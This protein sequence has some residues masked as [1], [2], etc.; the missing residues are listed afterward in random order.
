MK[1]AQISDLHITG[2]GPTCGVA[3]MAENLARVVAHINAHGADMVLVTG[4]ICHNGLPAEATRAATVLAG[5]S[6]PY[7]ITP[8]NHD[9]RA[10][11]Q[12]AFPPA[13]LPAREKAH[14]SYV[15]ETGGLRFIALDSTDPDAPNGR[16]CP[17]RAAW[18]AARLAESDQ[19]VILFLHHPPMKCG[20]E[21][22]DTPPLEGASRL[23]AVVAEY[24]QILRILCGHIHLPAQA[25]WQGRLVCVAP[26]MGMRL[27]WTPQRL[28][29]S[30]FLTS[31]PAY[32][33]HMH[34]ADGTMVTHEF[35]LDAPDGPFDFC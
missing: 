10:A 18:L 34:N 2:T 24:P 13:T 23:G 3:P 21:E 33:W 22:T 28:T 14:L 12:T 4:D 1:I 26:S 5:L 9:T 31:A 17:A 7:F 6:M 30:R 8:G 35:S 11:L 27:S 20:L 19:P 32:L 16:I 15:V 29:P 25:L